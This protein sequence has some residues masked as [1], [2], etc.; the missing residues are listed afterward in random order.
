VENEKVRTEY[1]RNQQVCEGPSGTPR[2]RKRGPPRTTKE[3][4]ESVGKQHQ[5]EEDRKTDVEN[6]GI[7][8]EVSPQGEEPVGEV[9]QL[10]DNVHDVTSTPEKR[11]GV[12]RES[13][14]KTIPGKE[15]LK[16]GVVARDPG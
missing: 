8:G 5:T 2:K 9:S 11:R 15:E 4:G 12:T 13:G 16:E 10:V 6:T 7:K 3:S 1:R 14:T